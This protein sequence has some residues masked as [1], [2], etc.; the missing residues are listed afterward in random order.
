M[1]ASGWTRQIE[2]RTKIMKLCQHVPNLVRRTGLGGCNGCFVGK[3]MS[4]SLTV[5]D[6]SLGHSPTS[7]ENFVMII[8]GMYRGFGNSTMPSFRSLTRRLDFV[9]LEL[10]S[11]RQLELSRTGGEMCLGLSVK[12]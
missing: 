3:S 5:L 11:L 2:V 10:V 4:A 8:H 12:G 9:C 7:L 6:R 1:K